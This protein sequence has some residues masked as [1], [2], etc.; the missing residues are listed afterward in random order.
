MKDRDVTGRAKDQAK[1]WAKEQLA[2][3]FGVYAYA[4]GFP[5]RP[6]GCPE[7]AIRAAPM[8]ARRWR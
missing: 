4:Y 6:L 2:Y 3:L 8:T 7:R 5:L 1:G